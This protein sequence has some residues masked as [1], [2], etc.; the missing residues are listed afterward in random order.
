MRSQRSVGHGYISIPG[1]LARRGFV[2]GC[3]FGHRD[4]PFATNT[5]AE[6][7]RVIA[8]ALSQLAA[9][10]PIVSIRELVRDGPPKRPLPP[11][12]KRPETPSH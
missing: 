10:A 12:A 1:R 7:D 2:S 11:T 4:M 9:P 5:P 8:N 3:L 6:R